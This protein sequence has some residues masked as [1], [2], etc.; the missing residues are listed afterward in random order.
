MSD[1]VLILGLGSRRQVGKNTLASLMDRL[2]PGAW[3]KLSFARRIYEDLA[4]L[5]R[6]Q[7]GFE[8]DA[9]TP[10]Q[11]EIVRPLLI[12]LGTARRMQDPLHWVRIVQDQIDRMS[13]VM[14]LLTD[15]RY[16]NEEEAMRK[17]YGRRFRLLEVE[18]IGAPPPTEEE[19]RNWRSVAA[20]ADYV[21]RWGTEKTE[22][23]RLDRAREVLAWLGIKEG[24][25]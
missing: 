6:S 18:R 11:K 1:G 22:E 21:L 7:F 23:E 4:P 14:V 10:E 2:C 5:V 8:M 9:L 16:P 25:R 3:V 20:R 19:E 13:G 15:V 17:G 24:H 12:G